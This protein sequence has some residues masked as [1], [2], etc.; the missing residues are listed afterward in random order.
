[1]NYSRPTSNAIEISVKISQV[2]DQ[3]LTTGGLRSIFRWASD[4]FS[5]F[6]FRIKSLL[7]VLCYDQR[8]DI[9]FF[10]PYKDVLE[11]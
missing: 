3:C 1:M 7:N 2:V 8:R 10:L 6:L 5:K 9:K 11:T 4:I